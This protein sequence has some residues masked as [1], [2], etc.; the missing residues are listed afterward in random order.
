MWCYV[1]DIYVVC[2]SVLWH[3]LFDKPVTTDIFACTAHSIL[4][5]G[6]SVSGL[7][8]FTGHWFQ[9]WGVGGGA[10]AV[11]SCW[12]NHNRISGMREQ[13]EPRR[14]CLCAEPTV[15]RA[16]ETLH[17][18]LCVV[19]TRARIC[20]PFKGAQAWDIRSLEFSWFLRHKVFI[21]MWFGGKNINL[22]F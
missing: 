20:K 22:L 19:T 1:C 13:E 4:Y 16:I 11:T 9:G 21:G 3:V 8:A 12:N 7:F 15:A 10:H 2:C 14:E 17:S 18:S 6:D 5:I